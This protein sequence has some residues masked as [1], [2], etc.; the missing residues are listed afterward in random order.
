MDNVIQ[1]I[2]N[3]VMKQDEQR[4]DATLMMLCGDHGMSDGGSHG[5]S[6]SAE[7][8]TPLVFMSSLFY[9][10]Q[11]SLYILYKITFWKCSF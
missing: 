2:Y 4:N 7:T 11:G 9:H 5:G 1:M 10:G 6:S 8:I 3:T